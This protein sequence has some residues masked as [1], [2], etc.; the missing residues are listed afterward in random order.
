MNLSIENI[1]NILLLISAVVVSI[2][3]K[4]QLGTPLQYLK[5]YLW[6]AV[7]L[8]FVGIEIPKMGYFNVWWY[9]IGINIEILFYL[10]LF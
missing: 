10:F 1:S 5:F 6:Y 3:Y 9:N 8:V 2:Y 7:V 4:K